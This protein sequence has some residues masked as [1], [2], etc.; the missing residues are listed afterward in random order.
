M[1]E[2]VLDSFLLRREITRASI[3]LEVVVGG[4]TQHRFA[5]IIP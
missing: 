5:L 2:Y 4:F 1:R 3:H